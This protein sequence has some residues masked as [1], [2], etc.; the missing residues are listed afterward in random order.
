MRP[1]IFATTALVLALAACEPIVRTH[2]YTPTDSQ[3]DAVQP[4]LDTAQTVSAKIGR[5]STGGV[6]RDDTWFYVSSRTETLAYN[7][8]EVVERRVIAVRFD[9]D[10]VVD[11]VDR[12]GLEDGR[13]IN[14][15]TRAT[16]TFGRELT[17]LQ[18][19]FGN[20]GNVGATT[21]EGLA[22]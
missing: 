14:L 5:P 13:V 6:I 22:N 8:P 16:P 2:G 7:A 21:V 12:F 4:G 19:I 3:L 11:A 20:L 1:T 10:G 9:G 17:V 18:Q 15:V